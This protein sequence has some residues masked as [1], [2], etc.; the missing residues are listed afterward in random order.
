MQRQ[1]VQAVTQES[2]Q[3]APINKVEL[4]KF[5]KPET[6]YDELEKL[7]GGFINISVKADKGVEKLYDAIKSMF[8]KGDINVDNQVLISGERNKASLVKAKN[9][10]ENVI[11]TIAN[12][13]PEDFMIMDLT[14]A[15]EALGEILAKHLKKILLTEYSA[16]S[17]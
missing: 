8:I 9:S 10:L 3:T 2:Y 6:S 11:E 7:T 4:V 14:D 15:Y 16:N 5:V 1:A 12:G 17:V 13:M